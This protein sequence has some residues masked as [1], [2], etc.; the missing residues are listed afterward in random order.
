MIIIIITIIYVCIHVYATGPFLLRRCAGR[1]FVDHS[2][3]FDAHSAWQSPSQAVQLAHSVHICGQRFIRR[4]CL[5]FGPGFT[6]GKSRKVRL[7]Q[8]RVLF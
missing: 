3:S 5:S 2:W 7:L 6:C 1:L 8:V 4:V